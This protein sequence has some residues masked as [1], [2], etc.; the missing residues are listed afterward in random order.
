MI[1]QKV[2]RQKCTNLPGASIL[3][4]AIDLAFKVVFELFWDLKIKTVKQQQWGSSEKK[5]RKLSRT[6]YRC[7]KGLRGSV[8]VF[9]FGIYDLFCALRWSCVGRVTCRFSPPIATRLGPIHRTDHGNTAGTWLRKYSADLLCV[10]QEGVPALA[11][12]AFARWRSGRAH[13]CMG[14]KGG[15]PL[16]WSPSPV[17]IV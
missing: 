5:L 2:D 9:T 12:V 17:N 16:P 1:F 8:T 13:V 6:R 11:A 14:Y 10:T 7:G 15:T 4:L 3:S